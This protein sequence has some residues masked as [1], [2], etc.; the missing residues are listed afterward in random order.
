MVAYNFTFVFQEP[1]EPTLVAEVALKL[2]GTNS[3]QT[4]NEVVTAQIIN[5]LMCEKFVKKVVIVK[6]KF[7]LLN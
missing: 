6:E 4:G 1:V 5:T 7:I 2:T 3:A